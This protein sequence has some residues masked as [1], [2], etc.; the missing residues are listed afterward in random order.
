MVKDYIKPTYTFKEVYALQ[1]LP[2]SVKV[3]I[4]VEVLRKAFEL[5]KHN[6][7]SLHKTI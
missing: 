1:K 4:S 3:E 5:S 2:L 7:A 6:K